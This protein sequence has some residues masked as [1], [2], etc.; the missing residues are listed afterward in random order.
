MGGAAGDGAA[1]GR[2]CDADVSATSDLCARHEHH[3]HVR[4]AADET[5]PVLLVCC[6][7]QQIAQAERDDPAAGA[8]WR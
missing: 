1:A 6:R 7:C 2:A 5:G 4:V 8:C 3:W